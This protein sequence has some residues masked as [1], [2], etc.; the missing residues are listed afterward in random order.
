MILSEEYV[1]WLL[2]QALPQ[3]DVSAGAAVML[4]GSIAEGFGNESSDIDFLLVDGAGERP[5]MPSILF[6]DG[7]RVEVRTR[8]QNQIRAQFDAVRRE[9]RIPRLSEDL[10]NRCQRFLRGVPLRGA[11]L[12]RDGRACLPYEDFAE[13]VAGWWAH[14]A[15]QMMRQAIA[16]SALGRHQDAADT[17]R[18]GLVQ[19]VKSWAARRGETYLETKWLPP[20]LDRAGDLRVTERYRELSAA[21]PGLSPVAHVAACLDFVADLGVQGCPATPERITVDRVPGVTTWQTA[22][23]VHVV[24][25]G[26]DVFA[27]GQDSGRVWRS[28]VLGRSLPSVLGA[29]EATGVPDAGGLLAQFVR[30]GLTRLSWKGSGP[31]ELSLPLGAT[32][33]PITPSPSSHRPVVAVDGATVTEDRAVDLVPVPAPRF[34]AAGMALVWSNVLIENAREDLTGACGKEQWPVAE[35]LVRRVLR[36]GLRALFSAYGVHPLPADSDLVRRLSLLPRVSRE[37]R[38]ATH[39]LANVA[40]ASP[41]EGERAVALVERFVTL[42]RAETGAGLFP[43]SFLSAQEWQATLDLGH[44]WLRLGAFFDADIPLDEARDLLVS[45]GIQPHTVGSGTTEERSASGVR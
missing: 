18:E 32:A 30:Y 16:W 38:E 8:T 24:R 33:G 39:A 12:I 15:R 14:R 23:R 45:G 21:D 6:L 34:A 27:L 7:R 36:A 41:A 1:Q 26:Q 37:V 13:I 19:A 4:E 40:V 25:T 17:A 20:Q 31:I 44:D 29:A 3:V 11:E 5:S 9:K 28:V 22:R 10:L 42:L 35:L 2:D 43:A